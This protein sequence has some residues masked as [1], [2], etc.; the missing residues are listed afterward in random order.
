MI[1]YANIA[2]MVSLIVFLALTALVLAVWWTANRKRQDP[3]RYDDWLNSLF[4]TY[5][6]VSAGFA[7]ALT[8]FLITARYSQCESR[9]MHESLLKVELNDIVHALQVHETYDVFSI[10]AGPDA[11]SYPFRGVFAKALAVDNALSSGLF[12]TNV[13][14]SLLS[15][16]RSLDTYRY[17][18]QEV[19]R[20]S[21]TTVVSQELY[22]SRM[23]SFHEVATGQHRII[24]SNIVNVDGILKL[25]IDTNSAIESITSNLL[26]PL[27]VKNE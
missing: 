24:L 16:S 27:G 3:K 11:P 22:Q 20:L 13:N 6:S 14:Q 4:A 9:R 8:V 12:S 26:T 19:L 1:K 10:P 5:I 15:I 17:V 2:L 25:G 18:I 7:I 23:E 21:Y